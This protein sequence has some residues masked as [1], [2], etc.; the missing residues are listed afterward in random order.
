M[1][2]IINEK[3]V[4]EIVGDCAEFHKSTGSDRLMILLTVFCLADLKK[5]RL[6]TSRAGL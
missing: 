1:Y 3:G 5:N 2:I 6:C 4:C